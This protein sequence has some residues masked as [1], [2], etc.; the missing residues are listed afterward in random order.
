MRFVNPLLCVFRKYEN[1]IRAVMHVAGTE[2]P[3]SALPMGVSEASNDTDDLSAACLSEAEVGV[4]SNRHFADGG[5]R[6]DRRLN[7]D[8]YL[9]CELEEE[10]KGVFD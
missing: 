4:E 7:L 3:V 9:K 10:F 1:E 8:Q 5:L 6:M 2:M